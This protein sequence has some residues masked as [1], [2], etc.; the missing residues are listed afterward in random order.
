M[1]DGNLIR[2][3]VDI[4]KAQT[5]L[6][7]VAAGFRFGAQTAGGV[8]AQFTGLP[9]TGYETRE[10]LYKAERVLVAA[11]FSAFRSGGGRIFIQSPEAAAR[12]SFFDGSPCLDGAVRDEED[13][14]Q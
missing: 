10:I 5:V 3:T 2:T 13:D 4:A 1:A 11:G 7:A 12:P 8:E 6:G 9:L 14:H